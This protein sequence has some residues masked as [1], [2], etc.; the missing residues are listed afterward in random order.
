M[1][2][3]G[4]QAYANFAADCWRL[5]WKT[6]NGNGLYIYDVNGKDATFDGV[7]LRMVN[8]LG[9][10][11]YQAEGSPIQPTVQH[12]AQGYPNQLALAVTLITPR[13]GRSGKG[14][15]FLP[16]TL[17]LMAANGQADN[18]QTL[19]IANTMAVLINWLGGGADFP[20]T[21]PEPPTLYPIA[22]QSRTKDVEGLAVTRVAVGSVV[23]TIRGRRNKLREVYQT[24]DTFPGN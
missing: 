12:T 2:E 5:A 9:V 15:I 18:T 6:P 7:T 1:T 4:M 20:G 22:V 17:P 21:V 11:L 23:D 3:G 8:I 13:A 14:R 16:N 24:V 19:G 10:T